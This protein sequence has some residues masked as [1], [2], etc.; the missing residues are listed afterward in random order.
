MVKKKTKLRNVH[1]LE[2]LKQQLRYEIRLQE[3]GLNLGWNHLQHNFMESL[4]TTAQIQAQ[5][6]AVLALIRLLN[7]RKK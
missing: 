3:K 2:L 6:L 4:K 1:D 7:T 5:R